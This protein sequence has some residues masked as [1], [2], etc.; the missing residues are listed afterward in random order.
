M[1]SR[2]FEEETTPL[3]D[4][5]RRIGPFEVDRQAGVLTLRRDN[6]GELGLQG[7]L[8]FA[9]SMTFVSIMGILTVV[10]TAEIDDRVPSDD[11]ARLFA[12]AKNN[13]GFLWLVALF[14]LFVVVPFYIWRAYQSA[15][16]YS[17]D[18]KVGHA[19]RNG[20]DL[21]PLHKLEYVCIKESQDPDDA[22]LY[23][24]QL[25]YGDGYDLTL[26]TGY[27]ERT[28]MNLA[29]EIASFTL[30]DVVWK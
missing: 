7:C 30:R 24:L 12:P 20:R 2:S 15:L 1:I 4:Y 8:L 17:F 19:A 5:P 23:S 6:Q 26:F 16:T 11:A 18:R 13:F 3:A 28:V 21:F 29:N 14:L 27:E 22:Y 10:R 9:F 25:I